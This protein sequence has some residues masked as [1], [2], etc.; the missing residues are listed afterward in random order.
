[1]LGRHRELGVR[2][3][4]VRAQRAEP[5]HVSRTV[6]LLDVFLGALRAQRTETHVVVLALLHLGLVVDVEVLALGRLR[7]VAVLCEED[8][9][10]HL[11]QIV[12]VQVLALVVLLAEAPEP[13]LAHDFVLENGQDVFVR[14]EGAVRAR[15][16]ALSGVVELAYRSIGVERERVFLP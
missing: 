7:A 4:A 5:Y 8:A 6:D 14:T 11:P 15:L 3:V 13:V 12:L 1:M 10:G 2:P 16:D 9:L